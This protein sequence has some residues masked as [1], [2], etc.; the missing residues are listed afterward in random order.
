MS[1]DVQFVCAACD[2]EYDE[3]GKKV[4]TQCRMCGRLHCDDCVDEFGRCIECADD[5][6]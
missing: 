4:M 2:Q 6:K 3:N 5:N 1:E